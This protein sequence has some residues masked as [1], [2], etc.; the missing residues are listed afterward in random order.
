MG[1][2]FE[3]VLKYMSEPVKLDSEKKSTPRFFK[4]V[5]PI[6]LVAV[7]IIRLF[8][9][10]TKADVP[11]GLDQS[12]L[13][14]KFLTIITLL[15]IW[16]NY[17]ALL[18]VMMRGFY[19]VRVLRLLTKYF[20]PLVFWLNLILLKPTLIILQGDAHFS[21]LSVLLLIE[22]ALGSTITIY[23]WHSEGIDKLK[24]KELLK[25]FGL[26]LLMMIP[27][28]PPYFLQF[29]FGDAKASLLILDFT[30]T[31]RIFLYLGIIIPVVLF[32]CLRK[33]TLEVKHFTLTYICLATL[34]VFMVDYNYTY[35]SRPWDWPFHLCN[36]AMFI[37]PICLIFRAKNLFYFTYFINVV[38]AL[39]AMLMP[40]YDEMSDIFSSDIV[41]FWYNHY[42]AFFMPV[43]ITLLGV[44]ERPRLK[45]FIRAMG[46]FLAYFILVMILNVV[47]PAVF[48]EDVDFFFL[49]G[50][51]IVLNVLENVQFVRKLYDVKLTLNVPLFGWSLS[52]R[53]IYQGIFFVVYIG[54]ALGVWFVYEEGYRVVDRLVKLK[55]DL[56][57]I[58][59]DEFAFQSQLNG[60]DI[61]L[62]MNENA[63][64]KY[65]LQH[66]SKKYGNNKHYS[67]QDANLEVY[68]G[69]IFGFLGPNGAGKSTIIKS[70]VGIQSITEG[71]IQICGYDVTRQPVMAKRQIGFVPDHY[72]LYENLTGREYINYIADI[73]EVSKEERNERIEKYIKLFEL[74]NKIDNKIE[75]YSHGMKQKITIMSALVHNPKVWILDEP[76]TGLDPNSIFQVKECMKQHASEGNIVFFSSHIIDIVEKLCQRIAIIKSGHIQCVKT[77][78]EIEESGMTLEEFYLQTIEDKE[79]NN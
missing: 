5:I 74:E 63:G 7:F 22:L 79:V 59:L 12:P 57:V 56:D 77:V 36:T 23:Y 16:L 4:Y 34:I 51:H 75:T 53:P 64:I 40:N 70:T 62:P 65:E 60:K 76:L 28:M 54:I 20:A 44:F 37:I 6:C 72:A 11:I 10:I 25:V 21:L 30:F 14:S 69:E 43:L 32:I 45:Q 33:K 1:N 71:H 24:W 52:V 49:N 29:V 9:Y 48:N 27:V 26:L 55:D 42:I 41:E 2:V 68:G 47:F 46:W 15:S 3:K 67:V 17:V 78:Q 38:G 13:D 8:S 50:D 18:V 31:H 66:F 19:S 58:K 35:F 39:I 61:E 73:Y